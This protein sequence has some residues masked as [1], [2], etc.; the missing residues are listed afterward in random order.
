MLRIT[1]HMKLQMITFQLEGR[2]AGPWVQEFAESWRRSSRDR[3]KR[4]ASVDLTGVTFVD[5]DGK[6]LLAQLYREGADFVAADC[7]MR[8]LVSELGVCREPN[9]G[10]K[11]T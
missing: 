8:A 2:L 6:E 7:M 11:S 5:K 9:R 3:E 1:I 10:E 4:A